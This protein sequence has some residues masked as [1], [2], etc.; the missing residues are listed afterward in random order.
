MVG[1]MIG[2]MVG[3]RTCLPE[4]TQKDL[5]RFCV[6]GLQLRGAEVM[7]VD[8][9]R[10]LGLLYFLTRGK[11]V[12]GDAYHNAVTNRIMDIGEA[13]LAM[14]LSIRTPVTSL[15]SPHALGVVVQAADEWEARRNDSA[16]SE[17]RDRIVSEVNDI[18]YR[19]GENAE[20]LL[21]MAEELKSTPGKFLELAKQAF[22]AKPV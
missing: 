1:E 20:L 6:E 2:E 9:G 10:C 22:E 16:P 8:D 14:H 7:Y 5:M 18:F 15:P 4:H 21:T 17:D 13:M 11:F 19:D 12:S 3:V